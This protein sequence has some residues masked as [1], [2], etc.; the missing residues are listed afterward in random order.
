MISP[1]SR[2]W[3]AWNHQAHAGCASSWRGKRWRL[4]LQALAQHRKQRGFI[5]KLGMRRNR[6]AIQRIG[7]SHEIR[8]QNRD[9]EVARSRPANTTS[10]NSGARA[11]N[12]SARNGP[13]LTQVPFDELEVFSRCDRRTAVRASDRCHRLQTDGIAEPIETFFIKCRSG[14]ARAGANNSGVTFGPRARISSLPPTGASFTRL[15]LPRADRS[16]RRARRRCGERHGG[17]GLG[18]AQAGRALELRTPRSCKRHLIERIPRVLGQRSARQRS[19]H[20]GGCRKL[21]RSCA[22]FRRSMRERFEAL[23]HIEIHGRR[24]LAQIA[25]RFRKSLR[26]R[27]AIVDVQ[28]AAVEQ[29]QADVVTAAEGVIP[30]QPIE[31]HAAARR[32]GTATL[33]AAS[34]ALL[35]SMRL[36]VI[37]ALGWPVEPEVSRNFAIESGPVASRARPICETSASSAASVVTRVDSRA[38]VLPMTSRSGAIIVAAQS[39]TRESR[40]QRLSPASAGRAHSAAFGRSVDDLRVRGR[41]RAI[42]H[43]R[44]TSRRARASNARCRCRTE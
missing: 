8:E 29:H 43:A 28:R 18:R 2:R 16:H 12:T 6:R 33:A 22:S 23:R 35:H 25:Q 32:P 19:T 27:L 26:R 7:A 39:R 34:R 17:T 21:P 30:R 13:T 14:Q 5:R 24:D 1:R 41:H 4:R 38:V 9:Q 44:S 15:P 3:R 20:A 40:T 11:C 42:R 37:T 31:Q 36:V 10:C